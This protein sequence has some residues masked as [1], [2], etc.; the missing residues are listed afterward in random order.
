MTV[1]PV[2][3]RRSA[4]RERGQGLVE[5]ALVFPVFILLLLGI[6]DLGRAVYAYNTIGDAA[7]EGARVAIVNQIETS[8][9]CVL[10]PT[11]PGPGEP[12]L[13]DQGL[14]DPL[15]QRARPPGL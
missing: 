12:P 15:G 3:G 5:F 4:A 8:P 1:E 7:R 14:R 2:I 9:D 10:G 6:F 11:D 13:V